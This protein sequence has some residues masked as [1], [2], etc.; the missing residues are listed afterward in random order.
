M[1][2]P[3]SSR[4]ISVPG[5]RSA[6]RRLVAAL[7][8]AAFPAITTA[9][10][11]APPAAAEHAG[12]HQAGAPHHDP[13]HHQQ[14]CDLCGATCSGCPGVV[15]GAQTT[16]ASDFSELPSGPV[17]HSVVEPPARPRLLPFPLGPPALLS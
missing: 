8:L 12:H 9:M 3:G 7:L 14:C 1:R 10:P 15:A 4:R 2:T 16:A 5:A 6:L 17:S 11:L 13:A